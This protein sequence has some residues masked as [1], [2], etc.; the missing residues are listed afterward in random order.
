M[1]SKLHEAFPAV[2]S[3]TRATRC[4]AGSVTGL[5]DVRLG[6]AA[7]L[8]VLAGVVVAGVVALGV[9]DDDVGLGAAVG[10]VAGRA[11][12]MVLAAGVGVAAATAAL[13]GLAYIAT[14]IVSAPL[15]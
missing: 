3:C 2:N 15:P 9:L 1:A 11:G 6:A 13:A 5:R 12:G 4:V 10:A 7:V 8:G 14:T